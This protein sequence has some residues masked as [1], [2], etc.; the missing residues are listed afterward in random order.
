[1]DLIDATFA[2]DLRKQLK[3]QGLLRNEIS[4]SA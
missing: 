2:K 1:M 4:A 3:V